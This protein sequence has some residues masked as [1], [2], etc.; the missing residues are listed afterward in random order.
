M[1]LNETQEL[2]VDEILIKSGSEEPSVIHSYACKVNGWE[3][4]KFNGVF[5]VYSRGY[6]AFEC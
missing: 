4:D 1:S 5:R 3:R 6:D 2:K